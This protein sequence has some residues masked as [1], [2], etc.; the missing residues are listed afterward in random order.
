MDIPGKKW[1]HI[2]ARFIVIYSSK[3]MEINSIIQQW[4]H[5]KLI[6]GHIYLCVKF[7]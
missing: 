1:K 3:K 4:E 6:Y 2:D 7:F 5:D